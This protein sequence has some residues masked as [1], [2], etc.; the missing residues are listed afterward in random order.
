VAKHRAAGDLLYRPNGGVVFDPT[1]LR[2]G[3]A[4]IVKRI[5]LIFLAVYAEFLGGHNLY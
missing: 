4:V 2:E 1:L 5:L 3:E